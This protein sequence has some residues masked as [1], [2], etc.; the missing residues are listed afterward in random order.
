MAERTGGERTAVLLLPYLRPGPMEGRGKG[1][2]R[3]GIR[4]VSARFLVCGLS[5]PRP[6]CKLFLLSYPS[7]YLGWEW[8][9]PRHTVAVISTSTVLSTL[10]LPWHHFTQFPPSFCLLQPVS[11]APGEASRKGKVQLVL[12]WLSQ[13]LPLKWCIRSTRWRVPDVR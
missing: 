2:H 4:A 13:P 6:K 1:A 9:V 7:A 5:S 8:G 3:V 11:I 12:R 10:H